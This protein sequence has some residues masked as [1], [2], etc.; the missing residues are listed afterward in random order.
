MPISRQ[1]V[2]MRERQDVEFTQLGGGF[3]NAAAAVIDGFELEGLFQV[4]DRFQLSG[5]IGYL[6]GEFEELAPN[7]DTFTID[8]VLPNVPEYQA[9]LSGSYTAPL[10]S[11]ALTVRLD[12][13]YNDEIFAVAQN[14]VLTPSYKLLNGSVVYRPNEANWEIAIQ[15]RNLA[16]EFY[17]DYR[18]AG[19]EGGTVVGFL[20]PPREVIGRFTYRF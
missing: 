18:F 14:T 7:V 13:S 16:D 6:S 20:Q 15:G 3:E 12:Y 9:S 8:S 11:G 10:P 4:T 2:R 19:S 1:F 17:S 5:G